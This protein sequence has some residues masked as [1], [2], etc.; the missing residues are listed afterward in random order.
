MPVDIYHSISKKCTSLQGA[1]QAFGLLPMAH[2]KAMAPC[3]REGG[4]QTFLFLRHLPKI[5]IKTAGHS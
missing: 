5:Q 1:P 3:I 4:Q 2:G